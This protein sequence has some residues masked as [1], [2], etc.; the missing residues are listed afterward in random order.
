MTDKATPKLTP[1]QQRM[2]DRDARKADRDASK[3]KQV[4]LD[5]IALDDAEQAHG[6]EQVGTAAIPYTPGLP[7]FA[8]YR[9]PSA[10]ETQR[11]RET[12]KPRSADGAP[13]NAREAA[14]TLG[15]TC[16]V[17]PA[18]DVL[19]KMVEACPEMMVGIGIACV[20]KAQ[21]R[22]DADAK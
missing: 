22:I 1:Y 12:V 13:N 7:T 5:M 9:T 16:V 2:K 14:I 10:V 21:A 18:P 8:V 11:Y 20:N 6:D 19:N 15:A 3:A 17:Y 4:E